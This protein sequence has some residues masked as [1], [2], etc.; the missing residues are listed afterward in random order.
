MNGSDVVTVQ[1]ASPPTDR[2]RE[3]VEPRPLGWFDVVLAALVGAAVLLVYLLTMY[4]GL[5][6]IGDAAKFSFVGKIL[7]TPHAPGYPLWVMVSHAFSYVPW[8]TLAYRMNALSAIFGAITVAIVYLVARRLGAGY[9]VATSAA[10]ALGLGRSFWGTAG[11]AKTYTLNAALVAAGLLA[12][13][14]WNERRRVGDLYVAAAIFALSIGNHQSVIALVPALVL[15]AVVTDPRSTLRLKTL[16]VVAT[17]IVLGLSQYLLILIRTLQGALYLEARASNLGQLWQVMTARRF[18]H[19]IGA[20]SPAALLSDRIPSIGWLIGTE[21]GFFGVF[22]VLI[23]IAILGGRHPRLLLLFGLG[24][25]GV[26]SLTTNMS[27]EEDR[28]FLLSAFVMLWAIAAVGLQWVIATL[29]RSQSRLVTA[30]IALLALFQPAFQVVANSRLNDHHRETFETEYFDALFASLPDKV[31]FVNDEYHYNMMLLY[32]IL[33]EGAAGSRDVRFVPLSRDGIRQWRRD[34]FEVLAFRASRNALTEFGFGFAPFSPADRRVADVLSY[35]ELFRVVSTPTCIEIGNLGWKDV[36]TV[37]EPKG[38]IAARIDNFQAFDASLTFY[39][40]A[41]HPVSPIVLTER[42]SGTPSFETETF[43]QADAEAAAR[44]AQRILSDQASLPDEVR[45][46]PVVVRIA[47]RIN[48]GGNYSLLGL[49]F[50]TGTRALMGRAIVDRDAPQRA[51]LCSHPLA[52]ADAWPSGWPRTSVA[53]DTTL[54]QFDEGWHGVE[55]R[56]DGLTWRWT[57]GRAA[58]VVPL[59]DPRPMTLRIEAQPFGSPQPYA[60]SVTVTFNQHRFEPKPLA[61]SRT[62]YTWLV[63]RDQLRQG[64]N[65]LILEVDRAARPVD[66]GL[67]ADPRVLGIAVTRIE[68]EETDPSPR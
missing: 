11:Y 26:V 44:L 38:R 16:L 21:L 18:A 55:K 27:S 63:T 37:L 65:E 50:G 36:S 7:G 22:L 17:M 52:E 32:K 68:L 53:L 8:G 12:L 29:G 41:D 23:G 35:R 15:F 19:E 3:Y 10:L 39:A 64:L 66:L 34:G 2:A 9:L 46:A 20:Y 13:L 5:A 28:G 56:Q 31:A 33:G 45:N 61:A 49:D 57:G 25:F 1:Q 14:R 40:G 30:L 60:R 24:A 59:D 4:P 47:A 43:L 54:V 58:A 62:T 6:P 67:S 42:G 48:D 51:A